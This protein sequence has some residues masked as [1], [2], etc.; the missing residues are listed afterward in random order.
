MG[1]QL[2]IDQIRPGVAFVPDAANA[3]RRANNQ[4]R[5]EFGRDID[6]NS[7]YRSWADQMRMFINWNKYVAGV[8]GHPGHSKAVHPDESFHVSGLALDS[9]DWV[10]PRIV[11]ILADHGFIRNRLHV[12][13]ERHHFEYIRARDNRYGEPLTPGNNVTP[14]V[15]EEDDDML[16]LDI[17]VG[18]RLHKAALGVGTF[19]HFIP[20]D[21]YE[22]IKNLA[23][24][25]DKWQPIDVTQLP[26]ALRT[27]ACDL[28]IWD[29]RGGEFVVLDPLDN[30]VKSGNVWSA[31]N[32]ARSSI[33]TLARVTSTVTADYLKQLA[34]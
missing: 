18:A 26:A 33:K 31:V 13:G 4:V 29:I 19:R 7:T 3:F 1:G 17:K 2:V 16:M 23:R 14:P 30:S 22:H 27:W 34:S 24:V 28:H 11:A 12:P 21:P 15:T 25:D 6:V 32:A 20:N 9:D 10:H 8:A 5:A